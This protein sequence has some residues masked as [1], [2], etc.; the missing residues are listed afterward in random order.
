M[1]MS[2]E[3]SRAMIS[4]LGIKLSPLKGVQAQRSQDILRV[5]YVLVPHMG[6]LDPKVRWSMQRLL[7]HAESLATRVVVDC[8]ALAEARVAE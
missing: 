3:Q 1:A 6:K 2:V 4:D 8:D 7:Q 5:L